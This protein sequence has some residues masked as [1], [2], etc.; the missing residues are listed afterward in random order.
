MLYN[1]H[2]NSTNNYTDNIS[3]QEFIAFTDNSDMFVSSS[4]GRCIYLYHSNGEKTTIGSW[5]SDN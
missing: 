4:N 2:L 3:M 5:R 1:K